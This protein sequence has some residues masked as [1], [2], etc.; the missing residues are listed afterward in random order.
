M[1][2]YIHC[3]PTYPCKPTT[4]YKFVFLNSETVSFAR[5]AEPWFYVFYQQTQMTCIFVQCAPITLY[6]SC[7]YFLEICFVAL[8][9]ISFP[10]SIALHG[11]QIKLLTLHTVIITIRKSRLNLNTFH[12]KIHTQYTAQS[13]E[14]KVHRAL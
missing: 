11:L 2:V 10:L 8:C 14:C 1:Y 6:N 7:L 13:T 3:R 4:V 12:C 5:G 9:L